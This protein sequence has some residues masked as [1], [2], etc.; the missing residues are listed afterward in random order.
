MAKVNRTHMTDTATYVLYRGD[1][2]LDVGTASE[3]AKRRG[4]KADT[5]RFYCTASY[6]KRIRNRD[7]R[8]VAERVV[9]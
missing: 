3:I 8:L 1:E 6:Q 2:V 7:K 5:I 9:E 4:I